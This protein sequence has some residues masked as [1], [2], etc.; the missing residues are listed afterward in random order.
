MRARPQPGGHDEPRARERRFVNVVQEMA[1]ASGARTPAAWVL[2]RDDA[3][4]AFAA[5]WRADDAVV[6]VTRGALERLTRAELQGVVAHEFSHIVHGDTRLN[7]R[8]VGMVWGLQMVWGLGRSLWA[9]D[10]HG[11]RHAGALFGA[12][13]DRGGLAR[14]AR[15]PRCCRPRSAASASSWPTPRR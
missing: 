7:M 1:L 11:R 10:E 3:I 2:P 9:A 14:L 15:R 6:A 13:A 8:L 5:G 12:G 4:N